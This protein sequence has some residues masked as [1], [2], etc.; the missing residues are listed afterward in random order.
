MQFV[1][2]ILFAIIFLIP[3]EKT[4]YCQ[5][6]LSENTPSLPVGKVFKCRV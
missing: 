2:Q 6:Q 4:K 5:N 1:N 3:S